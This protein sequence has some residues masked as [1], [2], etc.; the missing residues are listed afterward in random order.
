MKY[1]FIVDHFVPFPSSEYGGVWNV[2]AEDDEEC[3][4]LITEEDGEFNSQYF[5]ELRQN[6]NKA[7]K[8]SLL[9]ELPSKVVTSFLT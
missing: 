5:S 6:I 4:D 7:D 3:F 1:L 8:Y 9:D 2:I